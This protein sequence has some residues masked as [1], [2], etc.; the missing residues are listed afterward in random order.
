[1]IS[2]TVP[3][4]GY[5]YTGLKTLDYVEVTHKTLP[6]ENNTITVKGPLDISPVTGVPEE[7]IHGDY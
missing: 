1:M 5:S 6:K 2:S 3:K 4:C 7:H